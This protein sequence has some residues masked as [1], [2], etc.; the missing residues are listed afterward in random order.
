MGIASYHL[1]QVSGGGMS[2]FLAGA[3]LPFR[4]AGFLLARPALWLLVLIPLVVN[5]VLFALAIYYGGTYF[6]HALE[7]WIGNWGDVQWYW[8]ILLT[9][10][11]IF[12][13]AIVLVLVYFVFTPVAVVIAAPF[14]DLLAE[15]AERACGFRFEDS[16]SFWRSLVATA[17]YCVLSQGKNLMVVGFVFLILLPLNFIPVAGSVVY[18]IFAGCW[19]VASSAFQFACF[20]C[21]RRRMRYRA[22]WRLLRENRALALGFG[23]MTAALLLVPFVNVL[24]IP[25]SAVGGTLFYGM[26]TRRDV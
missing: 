18:T 3:W 10:I 24:V 20:P 19:F 8:K 5:V 23:C 11:Q 7:Q 15:Q 17:W 26:A 9:V 13:W 14:N 12:F 4:G 25:L 2:A 1:P 16:L 21:D 6:S 22:K